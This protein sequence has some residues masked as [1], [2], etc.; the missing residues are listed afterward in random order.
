LLITYDPLYSSNDEY[1]GKTYYESYFNFSINFEFEIMKKQYINGLEKRNKSIITKD[2][3]IDFIKEITNN[4]NN[5]EIFDFMSIFGEKNQL[6]IYEYLKNDN[7]LKDKYCNIFYTM[8]NLYFDE[9]ISINLPISFFYKIEN[10]NN[11]IDYLNEKLV[12]IQQE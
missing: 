8:I 11:L 2:W 12:I 6:Y 10:K 1:Y 9:F 5:F 7:I 4:S 3:V